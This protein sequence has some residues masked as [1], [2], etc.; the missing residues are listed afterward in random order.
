MYGVYP[1]P[2]TYTCYIRYHN[3]NQII[4]K[5][6]VWYQCIKKTRFI[7]PLSNQYRVHTT[8]H[9]S[10]I[11]R[12]WF[13]FLIYLCTCN[14]NRTTCSVQEWNWCNAMPCHAMMRIWSTEYCYCLLWFYKKHKRPR[15]SGNAKQGRAGQAW[16]GIADKQGVKKRKESIYNAHACRNKFTQPTNIIFSLNH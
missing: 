9:H 13:C 15:P 14:A 3:C 16:H 12:A 1:Y 2:Y 4:D 5:V 11:S 7:I 10:G 8:V 6:S